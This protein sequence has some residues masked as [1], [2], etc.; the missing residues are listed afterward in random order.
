MSAQSAV[1]KE[2]YKHPY[3]VVTVAMGSGIAE[4]L[5]SVRRICGY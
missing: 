5:K 2:M 4:L 1:K 3:A